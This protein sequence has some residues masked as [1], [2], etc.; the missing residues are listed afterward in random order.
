LK[1]KVTVPKI[2]RVCLCC[3]IPLQ[4]GKQYRNKYCNNVCQNNDQYQKYIERWKANL[5]SGYRGKKL[6]VSHHIRRWMFETRN[7]KCEE[8]GW[9][10]INQFTGK[11]PLQ[12]DHIDGNFTN[13]KPEN[14]RLL[15]PSCHSLTETWGRINKHPGRRRMG[16]M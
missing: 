4:N 9:S 1:T 11:I 6:E 15:C 8:C 10:K 12:I 7:H 14:L 13:N 16:C 2:S 3:K 5:E